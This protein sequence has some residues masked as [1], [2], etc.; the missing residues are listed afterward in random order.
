MTSWQSAYHVSMRTQIQ[1]PIPT[2]K[3]GCGGVN[4]ESQ[5]RS[6]GVHLESQG[7]GAEAEASLKLTGNLVLL[8]W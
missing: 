2:Y 4:L 7:C 1:S 8:K 5:A 6:G 3:S